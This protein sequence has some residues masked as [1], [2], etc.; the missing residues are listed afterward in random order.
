MKRIISVVLIAALVLF[1]VQVSVAE[2]VPIIQDD[3]NLL[4][5]SDASVLYEAMLPVCAFCTPVFW[6]TDIPG[7]TDTITKAEGHLT[8]L[9]GNADGVI[10]VIDMSQRQLVICSSNKIYRT[11]TTSKVNQI[12]DNTYMLATN[13]EFLQCACSV[14]EKIC[15]E[16]AGLEN[17]YRQNEPQ[18][19][20]PAAVSDS[21]SEIVSWA[22]NIGLVVIIFLSMESMLLK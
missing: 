7:Q 16:L 8:G 18:T 3:A 20:V 19:V 22:L 6:S 14:F 15:D 17:T 9:L 1:A 12:L 21:M 5:E 10:F 13:G 2:N 4:S 11:L